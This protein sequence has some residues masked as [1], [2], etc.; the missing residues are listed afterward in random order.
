MPED[1][2]GTLEAILVGLQ[3]LVHAPT[4]DVDRI[5]LESL[6]EYDVGLGEVG[7]RRRIVTMQWISLQRASQ[8]RTS[9]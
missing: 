5:V 4:L 9:G 1:G 2:F 3:C 7:G 8:Q 6:L